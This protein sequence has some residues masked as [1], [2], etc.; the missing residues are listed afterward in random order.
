MESLFWHRYHV[1]ICIFVAT[2]PG[3]SH[4][5]YLILLWLWVVIV[6]LC[7]TLRQFKWKLRKFTMPS[8]PS[9]EFLETKNISL[10][11]RLFIPFSYVTEF[12]LLDVLVRHVFI[13]YRYPVTELL[14]IFFILPTYSYVTLFNCFL[15]FIWSCALCVLCFYLICILHL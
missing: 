2:T 10:N 7:F 11:R 4:Y 12:L 3:I 1:S 9:M 15:V 14:Y 8:I 6:P 13:Y 5:S